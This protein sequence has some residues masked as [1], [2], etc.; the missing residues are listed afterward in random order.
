MSDTTNREKEI[1]EQALAL[2]S[3]EARAGFL[4]GACGTDT[5]LRSHIESLLRAHEAAGRF[6]VEKTSDDAPTVPM[7]EERVG[8]VIGRYKLLQQIGEGGMGIVY[9]AEQTEPVRRRVALKIIKL[10][11]DTKQVVARFEAERQALAMMDHPN[12]ARVL[13]GGAT[14]DGRP[15]FVMELVQGVPITEFCDKNKLP[16]QDRL[17]LFIPVCQA[18]QS[19]HQ[20]GVIHRDIKPSNV[21]VTLNNGEPVPKVIDFGIAKATNQKLTEKTLFTNYGA[22]IGTPAYMSPEQAEMSSLDVDTRADV[23]SLGVLLYELLTGSTPFPE[24]RLRSL[25]YGEMQRVIMEEEPERP[26]TRLSTMDQDQKSIV[27]QNRGERGGSLANLFRG[28]LD[29]VVMKCLE[30]DRGRRYETANGLATDLKRFLDNEPV[31]ARPPSTAYRLQKAWRRNKL[32]FSA[33]IAVVLALLAGLGLAAT[34][35]RE[36]AVERDNALRARAGE[37]LQRKAAEASAS[38]AKAREI[39]AQH[40]LYVTKMNLVQKEWE[41]NNVRRVRQLLSQTANY[42]DRGFEWY[43]WQRQTHL[44]LTTLNGHSAPIQCV[45]WS[46]DGQRVLTGSA[47]HTAKIWDA[48]SGTELR[49][50]TGHRAWITSAAFSP[51][52]QRVV[53]G[54]SD[55]TA[56]LWD[57]VTG[58]E[59]RTF[60]GNPENHVVV[61]F[62]PDGRLIVTDG[63]NVAFVWDAIDGKPLFT[64]QQPDNGV[65][66]IAFSADGR[67]I[68]A[69]SWGKNVRIWEAATGKEISTLTNGLDHIHSVAFFPDGERVLIASDGGTVK[70]WDSVSGNVTTTITGHR[71]G[72][73]ATL[74]PDGQR[75]VTHSW[76]NGGGDSTAKVWEAATGKELFTIKG[77]TTM[78]NAVAFSPD[79]RRIITGYGD[80]I[81]EHTAKI[82]DATETRETLKLEAPRALCVAFSPDGKRVVAGIDDGTVKVCDATSGKELLTLQGH[83]NRV[84]GLAYS[85]DG[86]RILTGSTD[87]T[88][89]I[90]DAATGEMRR[91]LTGFKNEVFTVAFS[92]DGRRIATGDLEGTVSILESLQEDRISTLKGNG[93]PA[94]SLAF[95]PDDRRLVVTYHDGM[96]RVL[97]ANSAKEIRSF[98]GHDAWIAW[99]AF[100]PDGKRFITGSG[101]NLAKVWDASTFMPLLTLEGHL[102]EV[103]GVGYSPDGRRIATAGADGILKIWDAD[104]GEELLSLKG[105]G[106]SIAFSSDGKRLASAWFETISW[107]EVSSNDTA[108]IW[109]AATPE[110]VDA[111]DKEEKAAVESSARGQEALK[112]AIGRQAAER[113]QDPAAIKQWLVLAPIPFEGPSG[114]GLAQEQIPNERSLHPRAGEQIKIG[115]NELVWSAEHLQDYVVDFRRIRQINDNQ[116]ENIVGYAVSYIESESE[117]TNLCALIGTWGCSKIFLN[118]KEIYQ[119]NSWGQYFF[120]AERVTGIALKRGLNVLVMKVSN[121]LTEHPLASIRFTDAEGRP[122]KGIKVTLAPDGP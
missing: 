40:L 118:A 70:V 108:K 101:D 63:G 44:E 116:N 42:P 8:I 27:F 100:S 18:I 55:H 9:M 104:R 64:L 105:R 103:C 115:T 83:S 95:S 33:G 47:D 29:W 12:I 48:V 114:D 54:S 21:L 119:L 96:V 16:A 43:Y 59:I 26:S 102:S 106:R 30:K 62:S 86:K 6:L 24:K 88:A 76:D 99:V 84:W 4:Q 15:Y 72:I 49:T 11:M 52:G 122:I 57:A 82:W 107:S 25:G 111:W 89:R 61:A 3:P 120:D 51:D 85:H 1:F 13:D 91:V 67:R 77:P 19:A 46:P 80:S 87:R 17:E 68:V 31:V 112:A 60:W 94:L 110:Q 75:I 90:W 73:A 58:K 71:V 5:K 36:T 65:Q 39:E 97:D 117:Q 20:K 50:L 38:E 74:S 113:A 92:S 23:Y 66:A 7:P 41:Q 2:S 98:K 14:E 45:V 53:T 32:A 22:M 109:L 37:N 78:I 81:H 28:D 34:G 35:W 93:T 56:K 79:S 10:G 121:G 69:G